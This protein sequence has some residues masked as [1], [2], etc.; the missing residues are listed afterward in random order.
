MSYTSHPTSRA[1]R[2]PS[3]AVS[4]MES[5]AAAAAV[6]KLDAQLQVTMRKELAA[7]HAEFGGTMIYV[8]HDQTEAMTLANWIV[9]LRRAHIE[10]IGSPLELY[11]QLANLFVASFIDSPMVNFRPD[12]IAAIGG[13]AVT[14]V[15]GPHRLSFPLDVPRNAARFVWA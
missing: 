7:L 8:T 5:F 9:V 4:Q 1:M 10:Q 2:S 6:S 11:N 15:A 13:S 12:G 3:P 14:L